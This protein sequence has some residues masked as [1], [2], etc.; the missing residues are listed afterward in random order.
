M[1]TFPVATD[2]LGKKIG[3]VIIIIVALLVIFWLT[4][5]KINTGQPSPSPT[6]TNKIQNFGTGQVPRS[7]PTQ[8][9]I[10]T[11]AKI[12]NSYNATSPDGRLQATQVF[13]SSKSVSANFKLYNDYLVKNNWKIL[14]QDST[15]TNLQA[16]I[17]QNASGI[18]GVTIH[19]TNDPSKSIVDLSFLIGK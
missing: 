3:L 15:K 1:P 8:I 14:A 11:G 18:L 2:P 10:E 16:I 5:I 13:E 19:G 4:K 6:S 9:P 12:I 17:A 7:F